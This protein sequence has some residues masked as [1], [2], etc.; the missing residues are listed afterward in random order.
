M[1]TP[2]HNGNQSNG[3]GSY[4]EAYSDYYQ[5]S[6]SVAKSIGEAIDAY[7]TLEAAHT[8]GASLRPDEAA[9]CRRDILAAAMRL[10]TEMEQDGDE[11]EIYAEILTRWR[12]DGESDGFLRELQ[13]QQLNNGLPH[14]M[15]QFVMDI[16]RAGW[17]LGYVRAGREKK[18]EP[19]DPAEAEALQMIKD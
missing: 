5:V 1:T 8:E 6:Q 19:D 9:K 12:G 17:E 7:A 16:R 14:W 3:R 4:Y 11:K 2:D 18:K 15:F 10:V 13:Q